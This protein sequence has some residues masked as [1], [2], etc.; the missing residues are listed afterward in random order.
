MKVCKEV[1]KCIECPFHMNTIAD[2]RYKCY[3][4][5][6]PVLLDYNDEFVRVPD[7]CPFKKKVK[8]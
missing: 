4:V 2:D 6:P 5:E 3:A 7:W 1:S 8:E